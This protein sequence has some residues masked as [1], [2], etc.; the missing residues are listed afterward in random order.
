MF[1]QILINNLNYL[2]QRRFYNN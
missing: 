1:N 2:K